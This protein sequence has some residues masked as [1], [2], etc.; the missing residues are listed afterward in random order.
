M[1]LEF[2]FT[3]YCSNW[4]GIFWF[5]HHNRWLIE[6]WLLSSS[7]IRHTLVGNK[8]VDHSDVVGCIAC[9]GCSNYICILDLTPGYNGLGKN[10]YH[11]RLETF[12]FWDLVQLILE[13]WQLKS[14]LMLDKKIPILHSQ[15]HDCWCPGDARRRGISNHDIWQS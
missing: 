12:K 6:A 15:Y 11:M 3:W 8:T 9:R 7:N 13:V 1:C 4:P 2:M 14:F 10:S 5:Q